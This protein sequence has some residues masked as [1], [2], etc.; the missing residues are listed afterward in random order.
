MADIQL[1]QLELD[2]L[3]DHADD[4][5]ETGE[6]ATKKLMMAARNLF[7]FTT[8]GCEKLM[9]AARNLFSTTNDSLPKDINSMASPVVPVVTPIGKATP[10]STSSTSISSTV[11]TAAVADAQVCAIAAPAAPSGDTQNTDEDAVNAAPNDTITQGI[12]TDQLNVYQNTIEEGK[13]SNARAGR[14]IDFDAKAAAYPKI[15]EHHATTTTSTVVELNVG[16][17]KFTTTISTLTSVPSTYFEAMFSGRHTN[18][19]SNNYPNKPVSRND[20]NNNDDNSPNNTSNDNYYFIDRDGKHFRHILNFLRCSGVVVS[21]PTDEASKRELLIEADFY[22]LDSL[23]RVIARPDIDSTEHLPSYIVQI[24]QE[25]AK[26]RKKLVRGDY[27]HKILPPSLSASLPRSNPVHDAATARTSYVSIMNN[28]VQK[29]R[30]NPLLGLISLFTPNDDDHNMFAGSHYSS[31]LGSRHL[32]GG[33]YGRRLSGR[34]NNGSIMPLRF[35]ANTIFRKHPKYK[36]CLFLSSLRRERIHKQLRNTY[37]YDDDDDDRSTISMNDGSNDQRSDDDNFD[38]YHD[39]PVTVSSLEEFETNFNKSHPNILSRLKPLLQQGNVVICGGGVL[40]ALTVRDKEG[41]RSLGRP[42]SSSSSTYWNRSELWRS[43][44]DIDLFIYGLD[45]FEANRLVRQIFMA[46]ALDHEKWVIVR[47][48]GVINIHNEETKIQI[49]LRLYDTITEILLG[50]DVDCCCCCYDGWDVRVTRRFVSSVITGV[51]VLNSIH[52]WPRKASYELRLAKYSHRGYAVYLPGV[53]TNQSNLY[54]EHLQKS[55][56]NRLCGLSRFIKIVMELNTAPL[57]RYSIY[58]H[59]GDGGW[60]SATKP[61]SPRDVPSLQSDYLNDTMNPGE[62]LIE[63]L[64]GTYDEDIE[65][66]LIPV[67]YTHEDHPNPAQWQW[68]EHDLSFEISLVT[69]EK[70]IATILNCPVDDDEQTCPDNVPHKL[71]D[72]WNT[73]KRSREYLNDEM[74]KVDVDTVYYSSIYDDDGIQKHKNN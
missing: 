35:D 14:E 65:N 52:S 39:R 64:T 12:T 53:S 30:P 56:L 55:R 11:R 72:A 19:N 7:S 74:D 47:T 48:R 4:A 2:Q 15:E 13:N 38:A 63:G 73:E 70:A 50:F 45:K 20:Q 1:I 46:L 44:G 31:A 49:V 9:M 66:V 25:E 42:L 37:G 51:N 28:N 3:R 24:Q 23:V 29:S 62:I 10:P 22:G 61:R 68:W 40:R 69:R 43:I 18:N 8:N 36:S 6:D 16:G 33:S 54:N 34:N 27:R 17:I 26:F 41:N 5:T 32:D 21:L 58:D 71:L 59:R 60:R 67:V 57:F